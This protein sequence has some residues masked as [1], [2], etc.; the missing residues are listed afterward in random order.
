MKDALFATHAFWVAPLAAVAIFAGRRRTLPAF[1]FVAAAVAF[2]IYSRGDWM[3][4]FRFFG[5]ALPALSA[6]ASVGVSVIATAA[7]RLLLAPWL[8]APLELVGVLAFATVWYHHHVERFDTI[9]F[10]R[11]CHFCS[12]SEDAM[13]HETERRRLGQPEATMLTHDVGAASY[14]STPAFMPIDLLGL[15]DQPLAWLAFNAATLGRAELDLDR[16]QYFFHEHAA[17]GAAWRERASRAAAI[18]E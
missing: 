4:H 13:N 1:A 3:P 14:A 17:L 10:I 2:P 16:L 5:F 7:S 18:S 6:L 12:R 9:R 11:W 15:C 8:S